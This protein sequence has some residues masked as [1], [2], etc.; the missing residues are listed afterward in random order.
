VCTDCEDY[1]CEHILTLGRSEPTLVQDGRRL[2]AIGLEAW[3]VEQKARRR[4]GFCYGD[5][6]C[7]KCIVPLDK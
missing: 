7:G 2:Q 1:P 4:V 3:I 6:R 5:V